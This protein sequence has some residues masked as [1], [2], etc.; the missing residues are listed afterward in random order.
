MKSLYLPGMAGHLRAA[1]PRLKWERP[2]STR[3]HTRTWRSLTARKRASLGR[4][5]CAAR[6]GC[7]RRGFE[8]RGPRSLPGA[9]RPGTE[10]ESSCLEKRPAAAPPL[11]ASTNQR[12]GLSAVPRSRRLPPEPPWPL[13][14][15]PVPPSSFRVRDLGL[16]CAM[17]TAGWRFC[18]LGWR[19]TKGQLSAC[20]GSVLESPH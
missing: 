4:S 12:R 8:G 16:R 20:T 17:Q 11:A 2:T 9:S 7:V 6:L 19:T 10:N 1:D 15:L 5:P 18:L 3:T 14:G 13:F